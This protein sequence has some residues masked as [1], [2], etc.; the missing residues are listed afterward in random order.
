MTEM[1]VRVAGLPRRAGRA[2]GRPDLRLPQARPRV[3]VLRG[4]AVPVAGCAGV[5]RAASS[6]GWWL[7]LK[8]AVVALLSVS[9]ATVAT[10][11]LAL[12]EEPAPSYVAGDPAWAH[13]TP[14][15]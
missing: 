3:T 11:Q 2:A 6:K 8:V 7:R 4:R 10:V 12:P 9:A 14:A 15:G 5:V 1:S 13:V